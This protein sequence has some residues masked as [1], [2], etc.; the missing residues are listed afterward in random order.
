VIYLRKGLDNG[1]LGQSGVVGTLRGKKQIDFA[2]KNA[3]TPMFI[4]ATKIATLE[5]T[6]SLPAGSYLAAVIAHETGHKLSRV[7]PVRCAAPVPYNPNSAPG[8]SL[9]QFMQG[10][11]GFQD[12]Y[13]RYIICAF[14]PPPP[15]GIQKSERVVSPKGY[16][17]PD[18]SEAKETPSAG[19]T[20]PSWTYRLRASS[21]IPKASRIAVPELPIQTQEGRM[22]DWTLDLRL[23]QGN[24]P[25][26]W[27]DRDKDSL[28]LKPDGCLLPMKV[29]PGCTIY[30]YQ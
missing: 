24:G 23:I 10:G 20:P 15:N 19:V 8:L 29:W 11:S 4:D 26:A 14:A 6:R 17:F 7:H 13:V 3:G 21:I 1:V 30:G 2:L 18:T 9:G 22:M 12:F 25:W 27:A 28:C 5:T 16:T